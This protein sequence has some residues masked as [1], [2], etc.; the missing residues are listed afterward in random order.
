[1]RLIYATY[2]PRVRWLHGNLRPRPWCIDRVI[3]AE[4]W[5]FPVMTERTRL[6]TGACGQLKPTT[7]QRLNLKNKSPQWVVHFSPRC[8]QVTLVSGHPFYSCQLTLT[9]LSIRMP[10]IKLNTDCIC[11]GHQ[12]SNVSSL[13]ENSQSERANYC[14][15][16]IKWHLDRPTLINKWFTLQS[17]ELFFWWDQSRKSRAGEVGPSCS[18]GQPILIEETLRLACSR[19]SRIMNTITPSGSW[20]Y[21]IRLWA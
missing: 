10:T 8:S 17:R 18:L 12:A 3:K 15:H 9:W 4:V 13:Q 19:S 1:M 20:T 11:L 14:S 5:D 16:I 21:I 7:G 6:W 2:Q